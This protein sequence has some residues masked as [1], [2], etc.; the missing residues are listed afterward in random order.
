MLGSSKLNRFRDRGSTRV[1]KTSAIAASALML[2]FGGWLFLR[3][4]IRAVPTSPGATQRPPMGASSPTSTTPTGIGSG[5]L[6]SPPLPLVTP[7]QI[8]DP[9]YAF[10]VGIA[11]CDSLG[12]WSRDDLLG[13]VAD[14]KRESKLPLDRILR[15]ERRE[16]RAAEAEFRAGRQPR[17][18]WRVTLDGRLDYPMPYRIL[19]HHLGSID[20]S[21][22]LTISE[23]WLGDARVFAPENGAV[24]GITV[25]NLTAFRLE[26]GWIVMDVTGLV[27]ALLGGKIDDCWTQGFAICRSEGQVRGLAVSYNRDFKQVCGE[28]D[29]A[30]N[31]IIPDGRPLARGIAVYVRPWL[32]PD[33]ED[34]RLWPFQD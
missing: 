26:E 28:I 4:E 15:I 30:T 12:V 19:G 5:S 9:F 8:R 7:D 10:L 29:F 25:Q 23:W 2:A 32:L 31:E 22:T 17:R 14:Q 1:L 20:I 18:I 27:D 24:T 33:R 21:R 13:Y 6:E 34:D 3:T 11:E 16:V